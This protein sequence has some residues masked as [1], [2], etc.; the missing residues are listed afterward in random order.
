MK[1]KTGE[2]KKHKNKR[3][4]KSKIKRWPCPKEAGHRPPRLVPPQHPLH[5]LPAPRE[6]RKLHPSR[7]ALS[8]LLWHPCPSL[9]VGAHPPLRISDLAP[10]SSFTPTASPPSWCCS[11]TLAPPSSG[12]ATRQ[13]A[14]PVNCAAPAVPPAPAS[15]D[16]PAFAGRPAPGPGPT[17]RQPLRS[18]PP[19]AGRPVPGP[20]R[21]RPQ[22]SAPPAGADTL[23]PAPGRS[24]L[25]P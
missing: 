4:S 13:P 16:R 22:Q 17:R 12:S 11:S 18:A 5:L 19:A 2:T 3:G 9:G 25:L 23:R 15:A 10:S 6:P 24:C 20:T 1:K 14:G 8:T 21:Q 7:L